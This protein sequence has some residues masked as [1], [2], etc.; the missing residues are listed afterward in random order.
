MAKANKISSGGIGK[1]KKKG[2]KQHQLSGPL[3]AS[4]KSSKATRPNPFETIWS[5]RKFDILGK[6]KGKGEE[7]RIGLSRSIA[8]EKRKKTLLKEY[9]ESTKSAKFID[10]RLGE[11][12]DTLREYEKAILR[13]QRQR[14]SKV[15]RTS[16]YNLSDEEEDDFKL[17]QAHFLPEMDDFNEQV[18][19][20]DDEDDGIADMH[21]HQGNDS[22]E[23]DL[24][25][26]SERR[27][28]SNK[29]AY[30][31]VIAKDK[32]FKAKRTEEREETNREISELNKLT[33]E[34]DD[35]L[36]A[37][38]SRDLKHSTEKQPD[39]MF[40]SYYK[41]MG[42][43]H[44]EPRGRPSERTKTPEEIAQEE[45]E[46]LENLEEE[47]LSRMHANDVDEDEG[48][49]NGIEKDEIK[50]SFRTERYVSGD[51]LGDSFSKV[52]DMGNEMGWV[53]A[54]YEREE[55][56]DHEEEDST[57][58]E[59]SESNEDD[60]QGTDDDN[61]NDDCITEGIEY[62]G[63]YS[64]CD[65]EQSDADDDIG[66]EKKLNFDEKV[67]DNATTD[68]KKIDCINHLKMEVHEKH[69]CIQEELPYVIEAPKSLAELCSLLDHRTDVEVV[70]IIRRICA[71]NSISLKQ[72]NRRKIQVFY[73]VLL[74]YFAVLAT[75]KPLNIK[76]INTLV[77]PLIEIGREVPY[78]ASVCARERLIRIRMQFSEDI[79]N[80]GKSS[81][82]S[83]KTLNLFR[84]WSLTFPCSDF[85]HVVMTPV[86][87]LICEYLMRC[88]ITSGRDIAVGSFLCSML[89]SITKIS[90][91]YSPEVVSFFQMILMSSIEKNSTLEQN[92]QNHLKLKASQPW[93][94]MHDERCTI[95]QVDL[96]LILEMDADSPYFISDDFKASM[97]SFIMRSLIEFINLYQSL[98]SFP[99]IFLPIA[100]ML[101]EVLQN[102]RLPGILKSNIEE[103]IG[104]IGKKSSEHQI[105]RQPLQM[106]KRRPEPI[107]LLNPKFE[108]NF[109]KGIDYDP[110]RE[111][112]NRKKLK[113]LLKKE[114][115]GAV[116]ELRKDNHFIFELKEKDRLLQEEERAD[117]YG[118]ALAFLQEQEHAFKS[119]QLGKG[120]KKKK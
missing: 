5:R 103:V 70:E 94:H 41:T 69:A 9:E 89:H 20:D 16:K 114:A 82:P 26:G 13:M 68:V 48:E 6:K 102:A 51:D 17:S 84:L 90:Q 105:L 76:I 43:L 92:S 36:K 98:S 83:L 15:K 112:A 4:M 2:G 59:D 80:P 86:L 117:K 53:D 60:H 78:F 30:A 22:L 66:V 58:T 67:I 56:K 99:E 34:L 97:L 38:S 24:L 49:D 64:A 65:W 116:R 19:L 79:K 54:I 62:D 120:R 46:A 115:K 8:I 21:L 100:T 42:E 91:K 93:L 25:N 50:S 101:R 27:R 109:V 88:P 52:K 55:N 44:F 37:L 104:L 7:I 57:S 74:N 81:W 72:E 75:R 107:K 119:G 118:K 95:D 61:A 106:R 10:R 28:K 39:D 12:D 71:C 96:F 29:Q 40:D 1:K 35:R 3:A 47:R 63:V 77:K 73:G 31:E 87:L 33:D 108:E 113:K 110:D 14:Q 23:S 111:R 18:P 11:K 85:R 45:R 32:Y